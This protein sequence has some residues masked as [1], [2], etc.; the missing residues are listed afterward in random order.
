MDKAYLEFLES[1]K[2]TFIE[3]GFEISEKK[4]NPL[5][6]DFQKFSVKVAL[7]KGRFALFLDCGLGKTFCQ[8]EWANQVN[9]KT[10]KPVLILAPLAIIQQTIDEGT[11]FA[12]EWSIRPQSSQHT[13]ARPSTTTHS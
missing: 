13:L 2:N 8:I 1:K 7:S 6:K 5:L 3:S 10:K 11:K 12:R 9:K 4:L